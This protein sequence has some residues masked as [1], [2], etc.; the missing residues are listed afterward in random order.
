MRARLS[1]VC[2]T[3]LACISA[4]AALRPE[5]EA[6]LRRGLAASDAAHET[7]LR[8]AL[9][10]QAREAAAALGRAEAARDDAARR[11]RDLAAALAARDAALRGYRGSLSE[12]T[13]AARAAYDSCRA[14]APGDDR[15]E[16]D[17]VGDPGFPPPPPELML[18]I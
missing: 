2:Q 17:L 13:R 5:V 9:E 7:A 14:D 16:D 4:R 1:R 18:G 12:V 10:A 3:P 8:R 15:F 6:Q 11:A